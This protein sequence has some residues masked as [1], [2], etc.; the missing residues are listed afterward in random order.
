MK[1]HTISKFAALPVVSLAVLYAGVATL[2]QTA[3]KK[4]TTKAKAAKAAIDLNKA[5]AEELQELRG[6]GPATAKK[7]IDGR[8]Y[9]KVDDLAKAGVLP[10]V[11]EQIRSQVSVGTAPDAKPRP[12]SKAPVSTDDSPE[13]VNIN[14]AD[15]ATLETLPGIGPAVA[16]AIIAGRPFESVDDLDR[17]RGL[18][19]RRIDALRSRVT[20]GGAATAASEKTKAATKKAMARGA[21]KSA[22]GSTKSS[23]K[24]EPGQKVDLN[25]ATKEE[26]DA[27]P[28]IGP[29]K[30]QAIIDAR[31]FKTI[32]DVMKVKGIKEGE[33][34]KI[35][36]LISV[37]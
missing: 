35:K 21:G 8:P 16:K 15:E 12:K 7:I 14:S 17:V 18:G 34:G 31:P 28:G 5:S 6:V 1:S 20:T 32:E 19:K 30:A 36:D 4:T 24:L 22:S 23:V 26:L 3:P 13:K 9:T 10:R 11:I 33:F 2:G 25:T 29:V 27:L 37:K